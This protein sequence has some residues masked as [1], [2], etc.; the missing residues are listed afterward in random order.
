MVV[1]RQRFGDT[2]EFEQRVAA[3][4]HRLKMIRHDSEHAI[5]IAKR[6]LSAAKLQQRNPAPVQQLKI[7]RLDLQSGIE[8]GQRPLEPAQRMKDQPETGKTVSASEI[9]FQRF[10]KQ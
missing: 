1:G 3:I 5:E 2:V 8:A 9:G 4:A 7:I 10:L 6:V